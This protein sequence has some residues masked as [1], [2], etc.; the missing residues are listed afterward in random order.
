M[1]KRRKEC[2][3]V[4]QLA[5]SQG[6]IVV[7]WFLLSTARF[8]HILR[9]K[10]SVEFDSGIQH[11]AVFDTVT[12]LEI[13]EKLEPI[14]KAIFCLPTWAVISLSLPYLFTYLLTY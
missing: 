1:E 9:T 4:W 11:A 14:D 10:R 5:E 3:W 13:L 12:W 6:N 2:N 8:K 7:L